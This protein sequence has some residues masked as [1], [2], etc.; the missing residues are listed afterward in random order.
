M[1]L[2]K[3]GVRAWTII[4]VAVYMAQC[5]T[6]I[7]NC[8]KFLQKTNSFSKKPLL[9]EKCQKN[10]W[11]KGR[12]TCYRS[13]YGRILEPVT[14]FGSSWSTQR[15]SSRI[16]AAAHQ[17]RQDKHQDMRETT[18]SCFIRDSDSSPHTEVARA[19]V[20]AHLL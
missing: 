18:Q 6:A 17:L 5:R 3:H 12:E 9:H 15:S 7:M 2:K 20:S 8:G 4:S 14:I 19:C 10:V 1:H 11:F 13:S 16:R